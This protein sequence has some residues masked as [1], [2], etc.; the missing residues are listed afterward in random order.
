M[1]SSTGI[2]GASHGVDG[3]PKKRTPVTIKVSIGRPGKSGSAPS[4]LFRFVFQRRGEDGRWEDDADLMKQMTD[5]YGKVYTKDKPKW[6]RNFKATLLGGRVDQVV[7]SKGMLFRDGQLV[8]STVGFKYY[9][10]ELE[11]QFNIPDLTLSEL[12]KRAAKE[13]TIAQALKDVETIAA[14]TDMT[15]DAVFGSWSAI[16]VGENGVRRAFPCTSYDCPWHS[17][18][19]AKPRPCAFV[20]E[21]YFRLTDVYEDGIAL[22]RTS[23]MEII[24]NFQETLLN[25]SNMADALVGVDV[26]VQ[27][28]VKRKQFG[29]EGKTTKMFNV[30]LA[31]P[32]KSHS[33]QVLGVRSTSDTLKAKMGPDYKRYIE[34]VLESE[35]EFDLG[36]SEATV[37]EEIKNE[38]TVDQDADADLGKKVSDKIA[39]SSSGSS[40]T[41]I[42]SALPG[43]E[44]GGEDKEEEFTA[45]ALLGIS[46]AAVEKLRGAIKPKDFDAL[47]EKIH[48]LPERM[49]RSIVNRINEEKK[50]TLKLFKTIK[51][52][53]DG[54][55]GD[56]EQKDEEK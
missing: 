6:V 10:H 56:N 30:A 5:K 11:E 42:E 39:A 34:G 38:F 48:K 17:G 2:H 36:A 1:T 35:V 55:S 4:K 8:C 25:A 53:V 24:Q 51:E 14:N 46:E 26:D 31:L 33:D 9:R 43:T 19:E 13:P 54:Q 41:P 32:G 44:G 12:R 22:F 15:M 52:W 20:G 37:H 7:T 23:S 27:G 50:L 28:T 16:R 47:I 29:S 40:D 3:T 45:T 18:K 21:F 49:K